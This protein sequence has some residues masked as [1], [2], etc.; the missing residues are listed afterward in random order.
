M[1]IFHFSP[2]DSSQ[3]CLYVVTKFLTQLGSSGPASE[4]L[5]LQVPPHLLQA[6]AF[7][8]HLLS[9]NPL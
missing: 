2:G 3:N 9:G 6:S 4:F 7:D 8:C 5:P 1:L